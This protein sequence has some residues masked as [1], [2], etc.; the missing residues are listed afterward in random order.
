MG[1]LIVSEERVDSPYD[2]PELYDRM[3][4]DLDFDQAFW[5]RVA[6]E[7]EAA[8]RGPGA[9]LDVGC[10]TGRVLLRLLDA[11]IDAD[12]LDASAPML[13]RARERAAARG[14]HPRLELAD[15]RDFTMPR[16]YARVICAFNAFAHCETVDDQ[17]RALAC[18]RRH[19]APGGA[20]VVFMSFPAP[21][22]WS[23]PDGEPVLEREIT[24]PGSDHRLQMWDTRFK[25][26]VLQLQRSRMEI[27]E[28]DATGAQIATHRAEANQR[29]VYR[30]EMELL[31]RT[32]GFPRWEIQGGFE[33]GPLERPDQP[34]IARGYAE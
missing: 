7:G 1:G 6:R 30:W 23:E 24:I 13:A 8:G 18:M 28:L 31:L 16:R 26:P 27:R 32:A 25:D 21:R 19:L 2:Q 22:Y 34:M 33:G 4:D 3:L 20:A 14:F 11:G 29:W 17:L 10:G 9:L 12:G 15:M 5:L